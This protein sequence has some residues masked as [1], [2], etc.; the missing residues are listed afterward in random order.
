MEVYVLHPFAWGS[1]PDVDLPD[2][3]WFLDVVPGCSTV[4]VLDDAPG[5]FLIPP[6]VL[7]SVSSESSGNLFNN[8]CFKK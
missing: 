8:S 7:I 3:W 6:A 4:V 2:N 1:I 5:L